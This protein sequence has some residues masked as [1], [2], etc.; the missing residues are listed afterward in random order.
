ML[1]LS[2][3]VIIFFT[4]F[5]GIITMIANEEYRYIFFPVI[6]FFWVLYTFF[7]EED[8]EHRR[9]NGEYYE[10]NSYNRKHNSWYLPDDDDMMPYGGYNNPYYRT[11]RTSSI[12]RSQE[13]K[14]IVKR[15]KRTLKVSLFKESEEN[16]E[17]K[18]K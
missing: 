6:T 5:M 3:R 7:E 14:N 12:N 4:S 8:K 2:F 1:Y 15:C 13:Y 9:R 17:T 11:P 16:G 18:D 10:V